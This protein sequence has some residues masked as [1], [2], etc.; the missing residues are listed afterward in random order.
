VAALPGEG[1]EVLRG[2]FQTEKYSVLFPNSYTPIPAVD[3]RNLTWTIRFAG[4]QHASP[5]PELRLAAVEN[6]VSCLPIRPM[7]DLELLTDDHTL[8]ASQVVHIVALLRAVVDGQFQEAALLSELGRQVELLHSQ[9][10][11]HFEFEED[12]AFPRL[13]AQFPNLDSKLQGFIMQHDQ[14]LDALDGLR[15]TLKGAVSLP[16]H[17]ELLSKATFFESA[18]E[19]HATS[20]TQLFRELATQISGRLRP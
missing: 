2:R 1:R 3:E 13:E 20:E 17:A 9:L 7:I 6:T 12:V 11:K 18:F 8:L 15:S 5:R 19:Q 16:A 10:I 4:Q 14:I